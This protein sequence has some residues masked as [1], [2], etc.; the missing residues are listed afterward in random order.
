MSF[1]VDSVGNGEINSQNVN[2]ALKM[3]FDASLSLKVTWSN[4]N[5]HSL[6]PE[7]RTMK[8]FEALGN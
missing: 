5:V 2:M 1:I 3:H 4:S 8:D 6:L 7:G